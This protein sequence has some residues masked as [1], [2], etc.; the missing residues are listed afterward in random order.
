MSND[1]TTLQ[2]PTQ[3]YTATLN[4][5]LPDTCVIGVIEN[6]LYAQGMDPE[7]IAA[8]EQALRY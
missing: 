3:D 5:K 4:G 7:V 1:T 8:I 2:E 6:A